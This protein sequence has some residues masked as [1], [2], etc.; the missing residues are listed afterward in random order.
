MKLPEIITTMDGNDF[1]FGENI[2]DIANRPYWTRFWVIQEFLLARQIHVWCSNQVID[3]LHFK[4][5][6]G[7]ETNLDLYGSEGYEKSFTSKLK[8]LRLLSGRHPD[9]HPELKQSLYELLLHHRDFDCRDPRD[10][11]FSLLSLMHADDQARFY[12]IFP[13]YNLSH[14]EVVVITLSYCIEHCRMEF[15]RQP[16]Y[17]HLFQALGVADG[18]KKKRLLAFANRFHYS[19]AADGCRVRD[20]FG[21]DHQSMSFIASTSFLADEETPLI[22]TNSFLDNDNNLFPFEH[23][24][25]RRARKSWFSLAL[26]LSVIVAAGVLYLKY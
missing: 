7:R 16:N 14:D 11:V 21:W 1:D 2:Q 5:V 17:A 12:R 4:G 9:R 6:V 26:G 19:D 24:T 25:R 20:L 13:D 8:A 15:R 10:R 3:D 23:R 22:A 18:S